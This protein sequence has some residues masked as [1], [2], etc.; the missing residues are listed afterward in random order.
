MRRTKYKIFISF[1]I[2]AFLSLQWSAAHIH[3]SQKHNHHGEE[4]NHSARIHN[5]DLSTHL[6]D[7]ID[8]TDSL[9]HDK[10]T[11]ELKQ[12]CSPYGVKIYSPVANLQT[13]R[14]NIVATIFTVQRYNNTRNILSHNRHLQHSIHLSRAPPRII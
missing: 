3:L 14:L 13:A 4:H 1:L 6:A 11:V 2:T 7:A 9:Q 10:T 5:H 12:Q 8:V